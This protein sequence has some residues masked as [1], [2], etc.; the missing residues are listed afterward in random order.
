MVALLML[1]AALS[2]IVNPVVDDSV[3]LYECLERQELQC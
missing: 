1:L 3:L 2:F